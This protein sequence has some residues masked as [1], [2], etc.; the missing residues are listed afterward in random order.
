MMLIDRRGGGGYI[1]RTSGQKIVEREMGRGRKMGNLTG[2]RERNPM[3]GFF[4]FT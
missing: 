1:E 4:N 2:I 3:G